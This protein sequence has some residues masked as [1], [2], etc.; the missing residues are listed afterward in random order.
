MESSSVALQI[1]LVDDHT[2]FLKSVTSL[3]HAEL[4]G[5][6]VTLQA[7]NGE[8]VVAKLPAMKRVPDILLLDMD[9]PK[10]GG[11]ETASWVYK[12]YPS[13]K[14][15]ALT[16]NDDDRSILRMIRAG[17]C[18]YLTKDIEPLD[19]EIALR[20]T[21][22]LG[23]YNSDVRYRNYMRLLREAQQTTAIQLTDVEQQF[24]ELACSDRT[25][26]EVADKMN[27]AERTVDGY[28]EKLFDKFNVQSRVGLVIEGIREGFL[29]I[30][31]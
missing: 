2:L 22:T 16:M 18:A 26:K 15:I 7:T 17:C 12:H 13:I 24:L 28:R 21:H 5:I 9:M 30:E 29:K 6:R 8:E 14:L 19:L 11:A 25:Y 27:K 4:K 31:K 3:I 1:G 23:F 10:M 20:E